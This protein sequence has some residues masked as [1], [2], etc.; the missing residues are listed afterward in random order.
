MP[1]DP[2]PHADDPA[3]HREPDAEPA[4]GAARGGKPQPPPPGRGKVRA[5]QNVQQT[6]RYAFRRH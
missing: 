6:R 3:P 2:T 5:K 4:T 1:T